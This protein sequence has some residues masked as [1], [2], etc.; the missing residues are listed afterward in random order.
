MGRTKRNR[1]KSQKSL[2]M[3]SFGLTLLLSVN[4]DFY[5]TRRITKRAGVDTY[6]IFTPGVRTN[7]VF[8]Y[9]QCGNTISCMANINGC[10]PGDD[11][12]GMV[13]WS[14]SPN[15]IDIS[16]V[17]SGDP[18]WVA[19]GFAPQASMSNSDLYYCFNN[20]AA[21]NNEKNGVYSAFAPQNTRPTLFSNAT[22]QI[23]EGSVKFSTFKH[24]NKDAFVCHFQ[25]PRTVSKE[26]KNFEIGNKGDKWT[27]LLAKGGFDSTDPNKFAYH[28]TSSQDGNAIASPDPIDIYDGMQ[29][30]FINKGD[31]PKQPISLT[32]VHAI[33]MFLD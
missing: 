8:D 29:P 10:Q 19:F 20:G 15:V 17:S 9:S 21:T 7:D 30:V 27:V 4:G 6:G 31:T 16:L 2:K 25:R 23:V 32:K 26:G 3:R 24:N 18:R 13:A 1:V 5:G 11:E 14:F 22:G 12:C 33:L 28:G